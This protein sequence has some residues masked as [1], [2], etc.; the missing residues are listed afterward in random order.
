[1][2]GVRSRLLRAN[3]K[4]RNAERL[5]AKFPVRAY[6]HDAFTFA[7]VNELRRSE[8]NCSSAEVIV[9]IFEKH[10]EVTDD[11]IFE[12]A[13]HRPAAQLYGAAAASR[14]ALAAMSAARPALT[15]M[16][17]TAA[18]ATVAAS[19]SL[20][21]QLFMLPQPLLRERC[22]PAASTPNHPASRVS[23][24]LTAKS[25]CVLEWLHIFKMFFFPILC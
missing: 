24:C 20:F 3:G 10:R 17:P 22:R 4:Q 18:S 13:S 19:A 16:T 1:M 11:G 15:S 21:I 8:G 6:L 5:P 7:D 23:A 2:T 25:I 12:A 9:I 14:G